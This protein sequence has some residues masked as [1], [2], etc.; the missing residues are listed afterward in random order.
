LA[1]TAVI[2]AIPNEASFA[3]CL[4]LVLAMSLMR[5]R[6]GAVLSPNARAD[7]RRAF[8]LD[9]DKGEG[10]SFYNAP[11]LARNAANF[12]TLTPLT[13]L[14]RAAT[15]YPDKLAVVHGVTRF[16]YREFYDRCRRLAKALRGRG[17]RKGDTVAVMAPNIPALLEAHYGVP[18]A[19]AVLNAL[20]CHL[21]ARSIAFIL[22]H[23]QAKLL[24]ADR[25]FAPIV[26]VALEALGSP[27]HL[28]E[29]DDIPGSASL[30]GTE[31]EAFL[32]EGDGG[33]AW[34]MPQDEWEPIALNYTSGTTGNPKGVVYHHR[35]AFLNAIGNAMT[36]KLA[37]DSVYLWTLP[38]FHCNGWTYTWAVTAVAGTHVCLRRANP[39]PIF[40]AI[41]E[42]HV[43]H[44]CGAP[45]VLNLLVNA[46]QAVKRRFDHVVEVATGGAAPPSAVIEAMEQMGFRV[47]HLYGLTESYGP[48]TVC[49]WQDAWAD[50]PIAQRAAR[51]ARQGVPYLT[52][53][54]QRVVDPETMTD[55]PPDG[56][57]LGELVLR[58]STLMKGYL[59]NPTATEAAFKGGWFHTGDL[60]VRHPDGYIEI[61]DRSKDIII[62]GGDNVSSLEIEEVLYRHPQIMEAAV[63]AKPDPVWGEIPCAFVALKPDVSLVPAAEIIAWCR[64]NL[65]QFKVPRCIVFGP[66]PKTSTGKIQKF[67]LRE[68][69]KEIAPEPQDGALR[70]LDAPGALE[71]ELQS[72]CEWVLAISPIEW[73]QNLLECGVDSLTVL[74]LFVE[75][76][77]RTKCDLPLGALIE[78]PTIAGIAS[79]IRRTC[80]DGEPK[81]TRRR[82][83]PDIRPATPA[84]IDPL[85][86]F[87]HQAFTGV[88]LPAWRR[89][90]DYPW[91]NDKPDLGHLL[92]AGNEIVGFL[93]AIY[94]SRKIR[95]KTGVVCN[96]TSWYVLPQYRGRGVELLDAAIRKEH[97]TFTALTP[98]PAV[99]LM[100]E[101]MGFA[102]LNT[103][104]IQLLPLLHGDT[105]REPGVLISF[106][107]ERVRRSL[108]DEQRLIFDD[109]ARYDC[110]LLSATIG[111]EHAF[112]VVKRRTGW[113]RSSDRGK[114]PYSEI[115]HCSNPT[116][117]ARHLERVKL[118]ILRRQRTLRLV[119]DEGLFPEK[120]RGWSFGRA[121][122][123]R[124]SQFTASELDKLYS[125]L[126]LLPV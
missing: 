19:G 11:H 37:R 16:T 9:A 122:L 55:V 100:L 57:A 120:P 117:L 118:A 65:A 1:R 119:C 5:L 28:V 25:E 66:L 56:R 72:I 88:P 45:I 23:G 21:D 14:P 34:A 30:G 107:P 93:G 113:L 92:T 109:H 95:G 103:R 27:I 10:S 20:N 50:L 86:R 75:L 44:L 18:M 39:A 36:F 79:L 3:G 89:L 104:R 64:A 97:V 26:K 84:D 115:L 74:N 33:A 94:A 71:R 54:T 114:I 82:S 58:S 121:Q 12:T 38:M 98:A 105:L 126:V 101:A 40:A 15:V 69:A 60:A 108:D 4:I 96:L 17:I 52:F 61:K 35:G 59:K 76:A 123:Y 85:C 43:T 81:P 13:F 29:I 24:I 51:M 67:E 125:E 7:T 22:A 62:V 49:A 124:S 110:L 106:D 2:A 47:T 87:L 68:R 77:E 8:S 116:L 63:V 41:A 99:I 46:S 32:A 112:L 111:S 31:Y 53:D 73:S 83:H 6:F 90:F 78:S 48:T 42:H 80:G 70:D 91:L 102:R